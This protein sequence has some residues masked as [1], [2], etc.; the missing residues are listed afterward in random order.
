MRL[1][2]DHYPHAIT[3]APSDDSGRKMRVCHLTRTLGHSRLEEFLLDS[4]RLIDRSRFDVSFV[5]LGKLGVVA[6]DLA[7]AG[8][9][10]REIP[11]SV[12]G[13]IKTLR[14]LS[15]YLKTKN[16]DILH[17]HNTT[18]QFIGSISA[19]WAGTPTVICT[20]H[21]HGC[22]SNRRT[23]WQ[24]RIANE[25]TSCVFAT[26]IAST[27]L[28]KHQNRTNAAKM[29]CIPLGVN[30]DQ[31]INSG[32]RND[33]RA[34]TFTT[35]RDGVGVETL[36]RATRHV[37]DSYPHFRLKV[38]GENLDE[39]KLGLLA[40]EMHLGHH[41][42]FYKRGKDSAKLYSTVGFYVTADDSAHA[43]PMILE[44]MAS[45]L[46]VLAPEAYG[47]DEM[48]STGVNGR[49]VTGSGHEHLGRG[50]LAM[51]NERT[52]WPHYGQESRRRVVETFNLK[53]MVATYAT[54]YSEL[55]AACT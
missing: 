49:L 46:P 11:L 33:L 24:F 54:V 41:V 16:I 51:V 18:A 42:E 40:R 29:A 7:H 26:S 32:P 47:R 44:A 52:S 38:V 31:F 48:V 55:A 14:K 34:I 27:E 15:R 28:C 5:A 17:T 2:T 12:L 50:M 9:E 25:F 36:I 20:Q 23:L 8:F 4:C 39:Q 13:Q 43:D 21:G 19:K 45:G 35:S 3:T 37:V 1:S 6:F 10:V 22:G 30:P 53:K